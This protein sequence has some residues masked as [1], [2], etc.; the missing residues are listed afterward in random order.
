M[1]PIQVIQ[2]TQTALEVHFGSP[3]GWGKQGGGKRGQAGLGQ[4]LP[5]LYSRIGWPLLSIALEAALI[6]A[7]SVYVHCR[8]RYIMPGCWP[9]V[10]SASACTRRNLS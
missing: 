8:V 5:L 4:A 9:A 10:R 2:M 1:Q 6:R 7:D 3:Q